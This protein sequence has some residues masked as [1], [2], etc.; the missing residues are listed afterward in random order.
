MFSQKEKQ[1]EEKN[2]STFPRAARKKLA[3]VGKFIFVSHVHLLIFFFVFRLPSARDMNVE[4]KIHKFYAPKLFLVKARLSR[5][6]G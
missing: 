1:E 5:Q 6:E 2:F 4:R 3:E